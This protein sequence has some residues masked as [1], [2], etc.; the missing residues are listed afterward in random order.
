MEYNKAAQALGKPVE[1]KDAD[2]LK[3]RG[4]TV[5]ALKSVVSK[6]PSL[7]QALEATATADIGKPDK[8][9]FRSGRGAWTSA[10]ELRAELGSRPAGSV[11]DAI[12]RA[13]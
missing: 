6:I 12:M 11:A 1:G 10:G 5:G 4:R 8:E 13:L 2:K 3:A 7:Y 9:A